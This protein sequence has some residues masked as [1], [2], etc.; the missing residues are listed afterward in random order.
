MDCPHCHQP[1]SALEIE[2]SDGHIHSIEECLSCGGHLI[3]PFLANFLTLETAR[4]VD[5]VL[6]KNHTVP[7][8][9]PLC[10][11]C[12]Q[13]M[14]SIKD[15]SVPQT[16]TVFSCPNNHGDFFPKN[17]LL[18]F[19]QA[20][21]SKI[22][23]HKLWGIPL[24]S[25]FAVLLPILVIFSFVTLLPSILKQVTTT[26]ETRIKASE[27]LSSPLITPISSTQVLIS[28]ATQRPAK[29]SLHFTKGLTKTY[30]VSTTFQT[31]HLLSIDE[32]VP[33]TNY[34]YVIILDLG[35]KPVTTSEY[36]FSTP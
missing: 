16:V 34:K 10:S 6:P 3:E 13:P 4:N 33:S 31:N 14:S 12:G 1:L 15:D 8:A 29:T 32:L 9:S 28:F 30:E 2:T 36:S 5:S 24:R 7:T 21:Q 20:Q 18:L 35:G 26:Q 22:Y 27:I 11:R 19:K 17:Q 23:F 25:A